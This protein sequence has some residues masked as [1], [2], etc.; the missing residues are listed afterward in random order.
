M[1][2]PFY[3]CLQV[4]NAERGFSVLANGP[5]DMRM[6]PQVLAGIKPELCLLSSTLLVV[7]IELYQFVYA[8]RSLEF[9][10][11]IFSSASLSRDGKFHLLLLVIPMW[12]VE[13]ISDE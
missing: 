4:N 3:F 12:E 1:R 7:F 2:T 13:F 10:V 8:L 9:F 5:L 11:M 6:D